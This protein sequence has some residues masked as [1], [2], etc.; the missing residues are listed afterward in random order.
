MKTHPKKNAPNP[1]RVLDLLDGYSLKSMGLVEQQLT[2]PIGAVTLADIKLK[3]RAMGYDFCAY[4]D[5]LRPGRIMVEDLVN[6][7]VSRW[8]ALETA[9]LVDRLCP[10]L[11]ADWESRVDDGCHWEMRYP[12]MKTPAI[13]YCTALEW[14]VDRFPGAVVAWVELALTYEN[15]MRIGHAV[16]PLFEQCR[17][18]SAHW[19]VVGHV[20]GLEVD[21]GHAASSSHSEATL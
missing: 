1:G 19:R 18:R 2:G 13:E 8:R 14:L 12:P 5:P 6:H 7:E 16:A 17:S 4:R 20:L 9:R 11:V 15:D 21:G 3:G 10:G